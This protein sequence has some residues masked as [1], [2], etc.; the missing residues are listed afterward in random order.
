MRRLFL[1]LAL[2]SFLVL[3]IT[4]CSRPS[5]D[6]VEQKPV[7]DEPAK[8]ART[9][10]EGNVP[11]RPAAKRPTAVISSNAA[12]QPGPA[13]E[14]EGTLT[15]VVPPSIPEPV[16]APPPSEP[17]TEASAVPETPK[18]PV[19]TARQVRIPSGTAVAL[20]MID[21]VRSNEAH[22]GQTFRASL[23]APITVNGETIVPAGAGA[24]VI[25][26]DVQSAG[27]LKGKSV[28]KLELHSITAG[29]KSN[30]VQSDMFSREG[31]AQG[32]RTA[33]SV[34]IGAAIGGAIGAI[35]G[36]KKGAVI[37]AGAGAGSGAAIEAARDEQIQIDSESRIDFRLT[38]PLDIALP[39]AAN[40]TDRAT[41]RS[42]PAR[43]GD[44]L[45]TASVD[46]SGEWLFTLNDPRGRREGRL[47]FQQNGTALRGTIID[48]TTDGRLLGSAGG[49][50]I[51]F[52]TDTEVRGRIVR[53]E[54]SGT[55]SGDRMSGTATAAPDSSGAR[56][57]QPIRWTAERAQ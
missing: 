4:S 20:R 17:V 22:V 50:S 52:T 39:A 56:A 25:L 5:A 29:N 34:G 35:T 55:I 10:Q 21:S 36:G 24:T 19:P 31:A 28:L 11:A 26:V 43:I 48:D 30:L 8:E 41:L 13:A 27:E 33:R 54:Y 37:G 2:N 9:A 38:A 49:N 45:E 51:R 47:V 44:R 57:D 53:M 46:V 1:G 40:S 16:L 32:A 23:D 6:L 3:A 14:P 18:A 12:P 42:G 7:V 15:P